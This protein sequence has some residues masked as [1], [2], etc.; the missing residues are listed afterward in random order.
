MSNTRQFKLVFVS[1]FQTLLQILF[2]VQFCNAQQDD[3]ALKKILLPRQAVQSPFTV[4]ESETAGVEVCNV[5]Y[6]MKL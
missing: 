6:R 4:K 2:M 5:V 1:T 3:P